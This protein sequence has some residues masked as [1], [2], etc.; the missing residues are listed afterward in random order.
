MEGPAGTDRVW[1]LTAASS[2]VTLGKL[3]PLNLSF[4]FCDGA[5]DS[6]FLKEYL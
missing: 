4:L 3:P 5:N 2:P 6:T 1:V